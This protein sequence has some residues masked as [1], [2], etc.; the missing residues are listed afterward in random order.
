MIYE[1]ALTNA[2]KEII[3]DELYDTGELYRS[4]QI[5]SDFF[6]GTVFFDIQSKDYIVYHVQRLELIER[7]EDMEELS[8]AYS[9][10]IDG[11]VENA[12]KDS[13]ASLDAPDPEDLLEFPRC[14]IL[15]NGE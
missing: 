15:F 5:F 12:I 9:K 11:S 7:L 14:V 1:G 13:L 10:Y 3:I 2:F 6:N 4:V 8:D